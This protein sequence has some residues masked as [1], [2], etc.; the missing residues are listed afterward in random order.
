[1]YCWCL[2][3]LRLEKLFEDVVVLQ[4]RTDEVKGARRRAGHK[5]AGTEAWKAPASS[6]ASLLARRRAV[7]MFGRDVGGHSHL[8]CSAAF[9]GTMNAFAL[10]RKLLAAVTS[11]GVNP[12]FIN[13]TLVDRTCWCGPLHWLPQRPHWPP[14]RPSVKMAAPASGLHILWW[15]IV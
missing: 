13:T 9:L 8:L 2:S 14:T 3:C 4:P 1:M 6:W 5:N 15:S 10:S 12:G 7:R 11:F